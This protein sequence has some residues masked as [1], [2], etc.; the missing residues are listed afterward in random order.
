MTKAT[1]SSELLNGVRQVANGNT[2]FNQMLLRRLEG[3]R[4]QDFQLRGRSRKGRELTPRELEV[5]KLIAEGRP[6]KAIG[7]DLGISIKTVEKHRQ[8]L[9]GQAGSSRNRERDAVR[10]RERDRVVRP[11]FVG[12]M[13]SVKE[14]YKA[15]MSKRPQTRQFAPG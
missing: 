7:A 11:A 10:D 2:F 13:R 8:A 14:I 12:A 4:Q 1:A 6:N 5:L 9:N 15:P 3:Q